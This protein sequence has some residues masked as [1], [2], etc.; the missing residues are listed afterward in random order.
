MCRLKSKNDL[1]WWV[2]VKGLSQGARS[3]P[4]A[5]TYATVHDIYLL[6]YVINFGK[7]DQL[8]L[9]AQ[10]PVR[11]LLQHEISLDVAFDNFQKVI[12][13]IFKDIVNALLAFTQLAAWQRDCIQ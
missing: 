5:A 9:L 13:R 4:K 2:M 6:Y 7:L 10:Q 1:T 11:H 12:P 3:I 8:I